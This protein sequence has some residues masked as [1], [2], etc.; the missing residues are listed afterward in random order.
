MF[1]QGYALGSLIT[2]I[3]LLAAKKFKEI[4]EYEDM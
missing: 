2:F 4:C 3:G 1:G